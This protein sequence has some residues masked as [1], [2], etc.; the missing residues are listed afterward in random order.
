MSC[1]LHM[2]LVG[3]RGE[4][5]YVSDGTVWEMA[6]EIRRLN[7]AGPVCYRCG[8]PM[9]QMEEDDGT[10]CMSCP[11]VCDVSSY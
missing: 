8:L 7:P 10:R 2:H 3:F 5:I 4:R 6:D 1:K 11:G 9:V